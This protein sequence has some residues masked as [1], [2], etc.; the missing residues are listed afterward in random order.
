MYANYQP[1]SYTNNSSPLDPTDQ[2]T[3]DRHTPPNNNNDTCSSDSIGSSLSSSPSSTASNSRSQSPIAKQHHAFSTPNP[4]QPLQMIPNQL[5]QNL[6]NYYNNY[7]NHHSTNYIQFPNSNLNQHQ[8]FN[9]NFHQN[10]YHLPYLNQKYQANHMHQQFSSSLSSSSTSFDDSTYFSRNNSL[11]ESSTLPPKVN[12]TK[13]MLKFSID[14]ILGLNNKDVVVVSTTT[15]NAADEMASDSAQNGRKRKYRKSM[16]N[17]DVSSTAAANKRIRTIFTQ[18]QLDKLEVEFTRQQYM[19]GSERSYLA[20]KLALSESQVK[21]WFQN[22]RIK[23]RKSQL[24]GG[25]SQVGGVDQL[26]E[27][28]NESDDNEEFNQSYSN[29]GSTNDE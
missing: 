28:G 29:D 13:S 24:G 15:T 7:N 12:T 27:E 9:P 6:H 10:N 22:R 2:Y 4:N 18:E 21:I 23:W 20:N 14:N 1:P 5:P 11:N 26:N 16:A 8:H 3:M 25:G 17:H 19:V